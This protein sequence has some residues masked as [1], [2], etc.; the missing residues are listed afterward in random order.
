MHCNGNPWIFQ[1]LKK[2]VYS[3]QDALD[4]CLNFMSIIAFTYVAI[5][6]CENFSNF[7]STLCQRTVKNYLLMFAEQLSCIFQLKSTTEDTQGE[8]GSTICLHPGSGDYHVL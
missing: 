5:M 7:P 6:I 2:N 8:P 4:G 3:M 1:G